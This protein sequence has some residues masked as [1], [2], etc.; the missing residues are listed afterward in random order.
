MRAIGVGDILCM[1]FRHVWAC[2]CSGALICGRCC[3]D[4]FCAVARS[5][6]TS[7]DTV[8]VRLPGCGYGPGT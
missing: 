5:G 2:V 1:F 7:A 4:A 6:G 8:S 3:D